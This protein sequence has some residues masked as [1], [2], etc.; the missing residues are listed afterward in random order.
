MQTIQE[1]ANQLRQLQDQLTALRNGQSISPSNSIDYSNSAIQRGNSFTSYRET[2]ASEAAEPE[3]RNWIISAV[4]ELSE[5]EDEDQETEEEE[6]DYGS[7]GN[8]VSQASSGDSKR[9]PPGPK[10]LRG[11]T[12]TIPSEG[13][14]FALM[15]SLSIQASS[16]AA[17]KRA[18][19]GSDHVEEE[20]V[21]LTE[22]AYFAKGLFLVITALHVINGL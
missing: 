9:S 7:N 12:S 6:F 15:A 4:S 18:G 21:G 22:P 13:S 19:S 11:I 16:S 8:G 5:E 1:Q 17:Q 14:P 2:P 10:T 3:V 20:G